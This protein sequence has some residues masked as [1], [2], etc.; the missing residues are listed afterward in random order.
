MLLFIGLISSGIPDVIKLTFNEKTKKNVQKTFSA[1]ASAAGSNLGTFD[2]AIS[3]SGSNYK[4]ICGDESFS[5]A[6]SEGV[7]TGDEKG[8]IYVGFFVARNAAIPFQT[9]S[10]KR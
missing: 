3:K 8:F 2:L 7:I 6:D 1:T 4:V 5:V 9:L 10:M